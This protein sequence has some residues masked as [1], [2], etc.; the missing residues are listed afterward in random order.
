MIIDNIINIII[1]LIYLC[2]LYITIRNNNHLGIMISVVLTFLLIQ[3]KDYL[4]NNK[5]PFT[6]GS[7]LQI[8]I[9]DNV[10]EVEINDN[11][12]STFTIDIKLNDSI[13][14][15]NNTN[16][17][18]QIK[19]YKDDTDINTSESLGNSETFLENFSSPT[20]E[21]GTYNYTIVER[22]N[23]VGTINI[24]EEFVETT[25]EEPEQQSC[26]DIVN[27]YQCI[28]NPNCSIN[29]NTNLCENK[30]D[31][32]SISITNNTIPNN[33]TANN[34]TANNY[35]TNTNNNSLRI[36]TNNNTT[37]NTTNNSATNN[38]ATNNSATNNSAN[39][40]MDNSNRIKDNDSIPIKHPELHTYNM[41]SFDGLCLNTGNKDSWRKSPD[42]LPLLKDSD[43]YTLQGHTNPLRPVITDYTSLYGPSIDGED[44]SPNKLFMFSNNL[45]SPSCCPS[46]FTTS[47]GCLCTSKKQRDFIISRGKNVPNDMNDLN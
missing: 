7:Q 12:F 45:S 16:D 6:V 14:W 32:L 34:Y 37:N 30:P 42:D 38:S 36:I 33:Y 39:D 26:S 28:S 25:L 22:D 5:Q 10:T 4:F 18:Y 1:I 8:D 29:P 11:G 35:T 2:I 46:T 27:S 13:R 47:T 44:D 24:T 40:V 19:I 3:F 41:S 31:T 9:V 23:F 43:L 17:N 21:I 15:T 20:Y